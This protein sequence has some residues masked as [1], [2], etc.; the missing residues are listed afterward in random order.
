ML[1]PRTVLNDRYI[2]L[3]REPRPG[4]L[5][6][7]YEGRDLES[8]ELVAI[9]VLSDDA[10]SPEDSRLFYERELEALKTLRHKNIVRLLDHGL[11]ENR[12][13][14]VLE[15]I[16]KTLPEHLEQLRQRHADDW[17]WDSFVETVGLPLLDALEH[18]HEHKIIHRDI[19][20]SNVLVD[21]GGT[22]KLVDFGISKL[23][24]VLSTGATLSSYQSAPYAP[25]DAGSQSSYSR[26][27]FSFGLLAINSVSDFP[28]DDVSEI[29]RAISE[30]NA[31]PAAKHLLERC[32]SLQADERPAN[33]LVL[34]SDFRRIHLPRI[35]SQHEHRVINLR[36]TNK[37]KS[38]LSSTDRPLSE[39]EAKRVIEADLDGDFNL[40]WA[41]DRASGQA[42]ATHLR[43]FGNEWRFF[44]AIDS[45]A[46]VLVLI[47]AE[48]P[49]PRQLDNADRNNWKPSDFV[50]RVAQPMD[51]TEATLSRRLF[52][53]AMDEFNMRQQALARDAEERRLFDQWYGRLRAEEAGQQAGQAP[54]AFK[55][56]SREG[57]R[58]SL[59]VQEEVDESQ[60][61]T[62]RIVEA[63][64]G[65]GA[66][67][68]IEAIDG[69]L[70]TLYLSSSEAIVPP[71]GRLLVD[72]GASLSAI[73]RQ[74]QALKALQYGEAPLSRTELRD[75]VVRP[76]SAAEAIPASVDEWMHEALD[77]DKK[78]AVELAL[79]APDYMLVEGPPGTGKTT[80]IAELVA[81]TLKRNGEARILISS[82]THVAL[83]N[84]LEKIAALVPD[85]RV[86]RLAKDDA[87]QVAPSVHRLLLGAQLDAWRHEIRTRSNQ[88]MQDWAQSR[89]VHLKTVK[90]LLILTELLALRRRAQALRDEN[91]I[92]RD[93]LQG[94]AQSDEDADQDS[95]GDQNESNPIKDRLEENA[96]SLTRLLR[97]EEAL[98]PDLKTV[99]IAVESLQTD[100]A[101]FIEELLDV[102]RAELG[103]DAEDV[104][105]IVQVQGEWLERVKR[106]AEF[107]G[108]LLRATDVIGATCVGLAGFKSTESLQFDLCIL[109]EAS[110]ATPTESLIPLIRARR[111]VLVGDRKQLPPFIDQA[112]HDSVVA[113]AYDIDI[114]ELPRTLFDRLCDGAHDSAH[115]RLSTQ[116]RMVQPIGELVS[117]CFYEGGLVSAT[118]AA[119]EFLT[120]ALESPVTWM[121]TTSLAHRTERRSG[122][123][124]I[125]RAEVAQIIKDVRRIDSVARW[126]KWEERTGVRMSVIIL[127]GY[128]AQ[129]KALQQAVNVLDGELSGL[130][131]SVEVNTVDRA[132]GR[133]ADVAIFSQTRSNLEGKRGFLE[134][135]RRINVAL[136]RGRS[137]LIIVGDARFARETGGPLADVVNYLSKQP[138]GTRIAPV[139]VGS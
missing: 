16:P 17:G 62:E 32:V 124:F 33:A 114:N 14:L 101:T 2:A 9:K 99:G 116:H 120:L 113:S 103:D 30:L 115:V 136:S 105:R 52:L 47:S 45:D 46:P 54:I 1:A 34:A 123:S 87:P 77:E 96:E 137:G 56:L 117:N 60:L 20:P 82:Q 57:R 125:N 69:D 3:P 112:L 37:V 59:Q 27:V 8:D 109:D 13:Y 126:K 39:S 10:A 80:F 72:V 6:L 19:K 139:E 127:S 76:S 91:S 28:A 134:D 106:G 84:A 88:F 43:I 35:R 4:G 40:E 41:T 21:D 38:D 132:Q 42:S 29:E 31:P 58:V 138:D 95:G 68:V 118:R 25:P 108:A 65:R 48:Q 55:L 36:L 90:R 71:S 50:L 74:K 97:D 98:A 135:L 26:D 23:K 81:Q 111:W 11:Q 128:L 83:D 129:V 121:D 63:P 12:R 86:V 61:E 44:A 64:R 5:S 89:G 130:A 51:F 79:G 104:A 100:E 73:E 15:W 78:R 131:I 85:R 66:K 22:P 110:K 70:L 53:E 92:L 122:T 102:T 119:N 107:E 24:S 75:V 67:G 94:M 93:Q 133:E 18:A 7:V 49:S